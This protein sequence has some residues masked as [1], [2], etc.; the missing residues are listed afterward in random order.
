MKNN[1]VTLS[2]LTTKNYM[3]ML[4]LLQ[5]SRPAT[6]YSPLEIAKRIYS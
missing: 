1:N 2:T 4:D 6:P 5:N 3:S